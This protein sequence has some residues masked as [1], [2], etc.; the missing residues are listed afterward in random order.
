MAE[1]EAMLFGECDPDDEENGESRAPKIASRPYIP[2]KAEIDA[3][4]PLHAEYRSWCKFCVEGKEA[5]RLH[6]RGDP[7]E[8]PVGVTVSIDY[9]FMT[10]EESEECIRFDSGH[11]RKNPES[12]KAWK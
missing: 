2:T 11:F 3:H 6:K 4:Y 8:E 5:S 7:T 9:C 10:P 12:Q 1:E